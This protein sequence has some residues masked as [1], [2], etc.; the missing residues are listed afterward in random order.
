MI[1]Y[2]AFGLVIQSIADRLLQLTRFS[3]VVLVH[4]GER[5]CKKWLISESCLSA[6]SV[7]RKWVSFDEHKIW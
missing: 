6:K 3:I 4:R 5:T 1:S 7:D 2:V